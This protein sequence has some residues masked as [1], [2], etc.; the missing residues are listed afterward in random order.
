M[1][2]EDRFLMSFTTFFGGYRL[3]PTSR[4]S[5]AKRQRQVWLSRLF[6]GTSR[7]RNRTPLGP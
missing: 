7:T 3:D 1:D 5:S 6:M 4:E 2:D